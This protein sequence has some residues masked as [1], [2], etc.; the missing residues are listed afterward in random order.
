MPRRFIFLE[1]SKR[2]TQHITL[3]EGYLQAL[4]DQNIGVSLVYRSHPSSCAAL[5]P[6]LR[7]RLVHEPIAVIDADS[8]RF[9][10]KGLLEAWQ[11][12]SSMARL[13]RA[14]MMLVSCVTSPALLI[15]ELLNRLIGSSQTVVVLHG[16]LEG[17]FEASGSIRSYGFWL[18]RWASVRTRSSRLGLAVIAPFIRDALVARLGGRIDPARLFLLPFPLAVPSRAANA[19]AGSAV[20][21]GYRTRLKGFD[22]FTRIATAVRSLR[23]EAVGNGI[24]ETVP[25]GGIRQLDTPQAFGAEVARASVAV[26]P[27]SGGYQASMSAAAIDA[28]S[29]GTLVLA[30]RLGCFTDLQKALGSDA[31]AIFDSEAEAISV[32][33]ARNFAKAAEAGRVAR[34]RA[35]AAS[36]YGPAAVQSSFHALIKAIGG[37]EGA[38][39]MAQA[40]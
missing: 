14:D 1:P 2:D 30:T 16:E 8:R 37:R 22:V 9:V 5:S 19:A 38:V 10:A 15:I 29:A 40:R 25:G 3:I 26:F 18:R 36:P 35:L 11:V 7:G 27:Y 21:I 31:V 13:R 12:L 23:F 34:V 17:L 33:S 6:D 39:T 28:V 24:V 32:L 20:F 4:A